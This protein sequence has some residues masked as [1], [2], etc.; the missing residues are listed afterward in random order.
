MNRQ[1]NAAKKVEPLESQLTEL[2]GRLPRGTVII[3]GE[4]DPRP[5]AALERLGERLECEVVVITGAG[6]HPWL[7]A[8]DE[9]ASALRTALE[10]MS[11]RS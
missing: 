10:P 6:H 3:G 4:A 11:Q 1:L 7:E 9:F 5:A 2:H 8:P